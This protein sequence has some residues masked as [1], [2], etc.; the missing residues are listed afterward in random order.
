MVVIAISGASG[1]V[2]NALVKKIAE[3]GWE[4]RMIDRDALSLPEPEFRKKFI[5]STNIIINLAGAPVTKKWTAEWK[6]EIFNSR[7]NTTRKIAE[8]INASE[9]KP[10]LFISASAIGIY[11]SVHTHTESSTFLADTFLS[12]VCRDWEKYAFSVSA[13]VRVVVFRIGMIVGENG[14]ALKKMHGPF[15]HGLGGKIGDG[16]QVI[17]FIHLTDM[18]E[19]IFYAMEKPEMNGVY[20]AVSPFPVTNAEFTEKLG[21]VLGQPAIFTVPPFAL[22]LIYGEGASVLLDG[23]RVLPER[24]MEA[25]FSFRYPTLQGALVRIYKIG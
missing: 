16:T 21:K 20:N 6:R 13:P 24:L 22:K 9:T 4:V 19:A 18:V 7:I 5:E 8:A 17:S 10:S 12:E 25:G 14:G 11:D 3:K 1:F 23:Q 15:S 2:G